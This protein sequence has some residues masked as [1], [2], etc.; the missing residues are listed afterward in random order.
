MA[1]PT[2]IDPRKLA[3]QGYLLEG[4]VKAE[5][6]SRL[7]SSVSSISGSFEASVQFE[8]DESRAKIARGSASVTVQ[9]IC[10]RCLDPVTV[11][12]KADFA[13]QVIWSEEHLNRVAKNYEP[14]LVEDRMANLSEL[15]EDEILLALPLVNYHEIGGCTGDS[16]IQENESS[17]DEA[18]A[19]NPFNILKQLKRK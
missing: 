19:D 15:L 10:Q 18:V 3:L 4:E 5:S 13:V 12:L 17:G 6:L 16:F 8:L 1:L 9:A 14:W 2:H 7:A 11:D